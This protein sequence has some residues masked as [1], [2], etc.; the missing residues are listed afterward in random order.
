MVSDNSSKLLRNFKRKN[1]TPLQQNPS[2]FFVK[3]LDIF[4]VINSIY[5]ISKNRSL[6]AF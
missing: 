1:I 3:Y 4:I 2:I 5:L 6:I